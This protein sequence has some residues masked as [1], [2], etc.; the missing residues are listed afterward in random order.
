MTQENKN[1]C[2]IIMPIG[3]CDGYPSDHFHHVYHNIIKPSVESANF[4]PIRADEIK[5]TNLIH[6]EILKKLIEAPM[7][8]CDLSTRNP[9][10]LFELGIRQAF[11]KPVVL[12]QEK[13]T[14]K[15][16]DISPLRYLEYSKDMKYHEVLETQKELKKYID[17]ETVT[18]D[19]YKVCLA[20]NIG[21]EDD[22][23]K[24][25]KSGAE[26]V[27]LF[28]TEFLFMNGVSMPDEEKQFEA[29]KKAAIV[30][31]GKTLTI[32]TLDVGGD[33]NIPYMGLAKETNPFLGYRAIRFC[34]G[35]VDVFTTQLRA[36][37]R[38]SAF[39]KV[40]IMIPLVTSL[41]EVL[42]VKTLLK[43][44]KESLDKQ[45]IPYDKD[46]KLGIMI[47]T[48]AAALI[49]DLLAKE[50][51]FFSI[52][53]NDLTQYTMAVDRGNENV[54]Y[55]YSVFH[56]SVLRIIKYII[57]NAKKAGIEAGMCGEAAG[58]P[59]MIPL[60][61]SFGLD[62]FSV[63]PSNVLETRKNIASWSIRE[64]DE[65]TTSVM[66]MCTE[67]EVANYLSDYIAAKEQRSGF[68]SQNKEDKSSAPARAVAFASQTRRI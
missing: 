19:G 29:Y 33:K 26:G 66:A 41:E 64:A 31:K 48:P 68:A 9:N 39:G 15:I 17:R 54:A 57:E 43:K 36:I 14:P 65:V 32:R 18:S 37:L 21:N 5:S 42:R 46:I 10:V 23:V 24:G 4:I 20:A 44:V 25:M 53:T 47:E 28:R 12:I 1:D 8:I 55:L 40:R 34:L 35:R 63:S 58:N 2:F 60:L 61:L 50:V 13:G 7:A 30:L 22:A 3:D 51:D 11:D 6:L 59:C 52:G 38:A 16:F 49:S 56:P 45:K 27:G 67:K 62:E